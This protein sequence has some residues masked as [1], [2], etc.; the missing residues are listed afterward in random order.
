MSLHRA[1]RLLLG[2]VVC[3]GG[4]GERAATGPRDVELHIHGLD[5]TAAAAQVRSVLDGRAGISRLAVDA[6]SGR[7]TFRF[8]ANTNGPLS[9][10]LQELADAGFPAHEG[11]H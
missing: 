11:A 8:D 10:A 3:I 7:A 9:D 2:L 6:K 4:C 1:R 5:S